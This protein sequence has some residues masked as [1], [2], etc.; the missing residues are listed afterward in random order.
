MTDKPVIV[1]VCVGSVDDALAAAEAGAARLELCGALELGGLTPSIGLVEAVLGEVDL[2]VVV[3]L[4]PR[5]GGFVYTHSEHATTLRDAERLLDA[6]AAGVV[7]GP[8]TSDA[9]VDRRRTAELVEAAAGAQAVFHR[10]L[11]F[12]AAPLDELETLIDL[13]VTRV[14]TTGGPPTAIEGAA[15]LKAM[16]DRAAGRIEVLPGGGVRPEHAAELLAATGCRQLHIGAAVSA[17][18]P[19]SSPG[20]SDFARLER[21]EHRV[22]SGDL[23]RAIVQRST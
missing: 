11:D 5:A 20:L 18:D 19:T 3:M 15:V 12:T 16:V 6:G 17:T 14:L 1:E 22:V 2:P 21:G 7:F 23:V 4:R 10:A 8:L 9:R 13:G